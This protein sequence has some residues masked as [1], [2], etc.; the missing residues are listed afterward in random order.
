MTKQSDLRKRVYCYMEKNK[1]KTKKFI[2][3]HFKSEGVSKS[4]IYSLLKRKESGSD[5]IRRVGSGRPAKIFNE[6]GLLKLKRLVDHKDGIYQKKL[7]TKFKCSRQYV[8]KV[9]KKKLQIYLRKKMDIPD[10]TPQQQAEAKEKCSRLYRKYKNLEWLLDDESYFTLSHATINNNDTF[11]TSD[12]NLT[13]ANVRYRPRKKYEPKCLVW[14]AISSKGI[15]D[16]FICQSG[17]AINQYVYRD[18]C[19]KKKLLPFIEKYHSD[20]NYVFWPDLA[21]SHY[22]ETVLDYLIENSINHVDKVDNPANLPE[23]R[24]IE[25]FWSILKGK[26]YANNWIAKD[27]PTLKKKIKKCLKEIEPSTIHNLMSGVVGRIDQVRRC[28]VIENRK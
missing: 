6:S 21:S 4:T 3:D 7:A 11:Y 9:L 15:S 1:D 26:V 18:E 27:I 25:D 24:P 14:V 23:C 17:M 22:A 12:R 13:P 8:G 16:P 2:A 28:G 19:L 5:Y 10:R 20:K